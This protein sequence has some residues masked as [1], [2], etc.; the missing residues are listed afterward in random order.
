MN[1][2]GI[3]DTVS[4]Q[5]PF[6][7]YFHY[8]LNMAD[9]D[10]DPYEY[11]LLGHYRRV[12][13][14]HNRPCTESVRDIAKAC[15]MSVGM[16]TKT[17]T[18]LAEGGWINAIRRVVDGLDVGYIVTIID[19]MKENIERYSS[20]ERGVHH[21]NTPK[22]KPSELAKGCSPHEQG[23]HGVK[24][25][26]NS[27]A[28]QPEKIQDEEQSNAKA[29][30]NA[31]ADAASVGNEPA[32]SQSDLSQHS[33]SALM[34]NGEA[35][36]DAE[37]SQ[38]DITTPAVAL[39]QT[40]PAAPADEKKA[41]GKK[42]KKD[43]P[44]DPDAA[45]IAALINAWKVESKVIDPAAFSKKPYRDC[46]REMIALGI[47]PDHVKGCT[48]DLKDD[49]YWSGRALP[50]T[51]VAQNVV[52]WSEENTL[53]ENPDSLPIYEIKPNDEYPAGLPY[54]ISPDDPRAA[55]YRFDPTA[56]DDPT[57]LE[58]T[59]SLWS[60]ERDFYAKHDIP[61]PDAPGQH[62]TVKSQP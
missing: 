45:A 24:Q 59:S 16:V 40:S 37:Q 25:R 27:T 35:S 31:T 62:P 9:D 51:T 7:E 48:A 41:K 2:L 32:I 30:L 46:A 6:G 54:G 1:Q 12:C 28:N 14:G 11:R 20:S 55:I 42:A 18:K 56:A 49:P 23:V 43:K 17:R 21:M 33:D 53:S 15:R 5:R 3:S 44:A 50:F 10:L 19:R 57:V 38:S 60:D 4:E 34:T 47:T 36:S 61:S 52:A 13:G 26:I 22:Q 58:M 8:M 29:L 39:E